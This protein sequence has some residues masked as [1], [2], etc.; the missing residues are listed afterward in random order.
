[1]AEKFLMPKL[2]PTMEEGQIARWLKQEGE[3]FKNGETL[4]EVDTDKATMEMTA[5]KDGTLLKI[6][7]ADG[8]TVPLG[9]PIA[10]T[11]NAGED[12]SALLAEI[13]G[14]NGNGAAAVS[15]P[16]EQKAEPKPEE[17]PAETSA[18][19]T[20]HPPSAIQT[21][22]SAD[23]GIQGD[24]SESA[25]RSYDYGERP[26][27]A[28]QAEKT[29]PRLSAATQNGDSQ[30][31]NGRL[32]IS[33]IAARMAAEAG[34]NLN[35]LQGS[36]SGGRIIK[37][38]VETALS[39]PPTTNSQQLIVNSQQQNAP[40]VV[41]SSVEQSAIRSSQSAIETP[42]H[43]EPTTQMRRA[44]AG[45][46][47]TSIGPVPTFYLTIE[48]EMDNAI[49]LRKQINGALPES[50]KVSL[51]DVV[52]KTVASAL[53]QHPQVNASY[54][55]RS[56]RFYERADIGVA[57]AI[58]DGLITPIIRN[59]SAKGIAAIAAEVKELAARARDKKLKPE[60]FTGGTFS[61]SN[62][63]MFGI[64][65]FTAIINPPEAAIL[66]VGRSEPKAVVRDGEIIARNI[67]KVTMSCDHRVID[68]ATGAA[69]LKTFK[70][71]LENPL[72][73]V[74]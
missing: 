9:D 30:E 5:L 2:S 38:D 4:A 55:D 8:E 28:E 42:F 40:E 12:I 33:P 54:Q 72:L 58:P 13:T 14:G 11:G 7:H 50:Q 43:D 15:H 34:L 46:L 10:I 17:K 52:I 61:I 67:M 3:A 19:S 49:D 64:E 53:M 31:G 45:R 22:Q 26:G 74:M 29:A 6:L 70:Q 59:A 1:M 66:A 18:V 41:Q 21:P 23:G 48:V 69:F 37:R 35:Q 71:M 27:S 32:I 47:V 51:N 62:L 57:V 25:G 16:A 44:I 36:G 65:E 60:E 73:L 56:I 39:Q 68:G 24:A 63:G 20:E